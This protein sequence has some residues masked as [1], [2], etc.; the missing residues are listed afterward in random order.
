MKTGLVKISGGIY[1]I[2]DSAGR[3]IASFIPPPLLKDIDWD[4]LNNAQKWL[5]SEMA[6]QWDIIAQWLVYFRTRAVD[7]KQ[8]PFTLCEFTD[9]RAKAEL[10]N[11]QLDLCAATWEEIDEIS[12]HYPTPYDWW[13]KCIKEV[14]QSQ[15]N[16][17]KDLR[18]GKIQ[19][20]KGETEDGLRELRRFLKQDT[21]PFL[22]TAQNQ[23]IYK[24]Y[25]FAI[26]LKN[27]KPVRTLWD[28]YLKALAKQ[29]SELKDRKEIKAIVHH[30]GQLYFQNGSTMTPILITSID[31]YAVLNVRAKFA[32]M[33]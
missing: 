8:M 26:K 32:L 17:V 19:L 29:A 21:I 11:I 10:Y 6:C 14:Q 23:H 33:S 27:C 16:A 7:I 12:Q 31:K 30:R 5:F 15:V 3:A 24:F 13:I 9:Q 20:N 4:T 18:E 22:E 2:G 1:K 25:L 28:E